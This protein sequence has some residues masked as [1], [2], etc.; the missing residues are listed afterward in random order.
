MSS[1]SKTR[2]R[3]T[4]RYP[5]L[6]PIRLAQRRLF[7]TVSDARVG[8]RY[9][10]SRHAEDLEFLI[11]E[12]SSILERRLDGVDPQLQRNKVQNLSLAASRI[13]GVVLGPGETFSFW[14][15]V[16]RA[17]ARGGYSEGLVLRD[18][19]PASGVGGGL[20]QISNMLH[21]L[22]LHSDLA[23]VERHRHSYDPFPDS[24]RVVP[25]GTGATLLEGIFDLK[26][27]N[28]TD[29]DHQVRLRL[30]PTHLVGQ[31]RSAELLARYEIVERD[32]RFIRDGDDVFRSNRIVRRRIAEQVGVAQPSPA[33]GHRE[34]DSAVPVGERANSEVTLFTNHCRVGYS[35][36][37]ERLS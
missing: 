14:K 26:V 36:P 8:Y 13:D 6:V 25:F 11:K 22:V 28:P 2:R 3:V 31:L 4:E 18:G 7:K 21:W 16:G 10:T 33:L 5:A 20:C 34:A 32:H 17:T 19:A 12:H 37:D 27:H 29:V 24:D 35:V 9:A 1:P 15:L 30:T 23:V